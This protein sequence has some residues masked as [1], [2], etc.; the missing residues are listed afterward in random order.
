MKTVHDI[1]TVAYGHG[2]ELNRLDRDAQGIN[3]VSRTE[4]NNGVSA[5]VKP[6]PGLKPSPG[7]TI[8]VAGNGASVLE[9]FLQ[10]GPYYSSY[11]L[12]C[13]TP[14]R[15]LSHE[16]LL[17]YCACIKANR[18][19]YNYGRQANSTLGKLPVPS[20][21]EIPEWVKDF[22]IQRYARALLTQTTLDVPTGQH[23][24]ALTALKKQVDVLV[25]L[26]SLFV[27]VNGIGSAGLKR[28][29]AGP[30]ASYVPYVRPS[31]RQ[32]TSIDAFVSKATAG[33]AHVFPKG[34][35][36]VSTNGQGS[37]TYAYVSTFE[38]VPNSDVCVLQPITPMS[39]QDKLFYALCITSNRYRY[40]YGRKPKGDRLAEMV[41][42]SRPPDWV[43]KFDLSQIV[44]EFAAVVGRL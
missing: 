31:Y 8:S 11:H 30:D 22:S 36:Y 32:A 14:K 5:R 40:S 38:F 28:F 7:G 18:F 16:A 24:L 27:P 4:K 10:L 43:D 2:L 19:K 29:P 41:L 42:P 15:P 6:I 23:G 21:E 17:Y 35:L 9:A 33:E 12:F 26:D 25:R 44:E 20:E 37:H 13:L 1:F 34:T 39:I 3:F